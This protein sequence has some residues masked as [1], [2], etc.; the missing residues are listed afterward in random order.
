M[1]R[2][3]LGYAVY[4]SSSAHLNELVVRGDLLTSYADVLTPDAMAALD[5][6][7]HFDTDRRAVMAGRIARRTARARDKQRM[8]FLDPDG[9]I[10]RTRIRVQDARD[11]RFIGSEIPSD[12]RRQW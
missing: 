7:A 10:P 3:K 2:S 5:A 6:L 9:V 1:I 11:G 4:M 8:A 12:L